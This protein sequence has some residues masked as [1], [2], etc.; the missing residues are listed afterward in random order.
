MFRRSLTRRRR[1]LSRILVEILLI[2]ICV[3]ATSVA[4]YVW[5][6]M[7]A[8]SSKTVS[9]SVVSIEGSASAG[10]VW[11]TVKNT[12]NVAFTSA[13]LD[14]PSPASGYSLSPPPPFTLNPGDSIVF[15]VTGT[16]T[17]GNTYY[18]HITLTGSGGASVGVDAK[19]TL[20]S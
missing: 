20:S 18:F 17:V 12:G 16:Y 6:S 14:S 4:Y 1:A 11:I 10:A 5:S 19:I 3:A 7:F 2:V 9:A 13:T 8:A 15:K